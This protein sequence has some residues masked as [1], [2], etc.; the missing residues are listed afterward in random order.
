MTPPLKIFITDT[1]QMPIKV[2]FSSSIIKLALNLLIKKNKLGQ[3]IIQGI[4]QVNYNRCL[5]SKS[6]LLYI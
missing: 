3:Y 5:I 4:F 1:Y 6:D 2:I